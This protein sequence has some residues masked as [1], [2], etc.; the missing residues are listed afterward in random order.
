M[1][2]KLIAGLLVAACVSSIA[3]ASAT[4]DM[5]SPIAGDDTLVL[6]YEGLSAHTEIKLNFDLYI[7]GSWDGNTTVN[8]N[9]P[10][11]FGFKIDGIEQGYW[12]FRNVSQDLGDESNQDDSWD[13][14]DFNADDNYDNIDRYFND[15][16]DGFTFAH[17]GDSLEIEFFGYG[18]QDVTDESWRVDGVKVSAVPVPTAVWLF[19]SG[20]LGLAG[21]RRKIS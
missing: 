18:L 19:G 2:R 6:N 3:N 8:G 12:T 21:M 13:S 7:M 4:I 1:K 9:G 17:S 16:A 20:L 11:A 10:D 14:G 5:D 15:Y